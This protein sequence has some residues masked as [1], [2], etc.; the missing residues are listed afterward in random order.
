MK[1]GV[2]FCYVYAS[3]MCMRVHIILWLLFK[4]HFTQWIQSLWKGDERH[5]PVVIPLLLPGSQMEI[6]YY[7]YYDVRLALNVMSNN[8]VWR[9]KNP[10]RPHFLSLEQG[11]RCD[12]KVCFWHTGNCSSQCHK[13]SCSPRQEPLIR[14]VFHPC[15]ATYSL[16]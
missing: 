15:V 13:P 7:G 2:K 9:S 8:V 1:S 3:Y 4:A 11:P 6:F 12:L 14:F 16:Q 5:I 10:V